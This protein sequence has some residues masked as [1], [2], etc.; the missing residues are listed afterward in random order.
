[1]ELMPK[2]CT[3]KR[4]CFFFSLAVAVELMAKRRSFIKKKT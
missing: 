1:L 4:R 3:R 2:S